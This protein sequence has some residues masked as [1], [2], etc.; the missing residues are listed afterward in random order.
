[1]SYGF[2]SNTDNGY[3]QIDGENLQLK[4]LA[5]G[6]VVPGVIGSSSSDKD[7][8]GNSYYP[9]TGRGSNWNPNKAAVSIAIPSGYGTEDVFLFAKPSNTSQS[10]K[11]IG[12]LFYTSAG[13]GYFKITCPEWVSW[14]SNTV[15]YKLCVINND[16]DDNA[17]YGLRVFS[18]S[19]GL[20]FSSNRANFKGEQFAYGTPS[21]NITS[22]SSSDYGS[23]VIGPMYFDK[24][25]EKLDYYCFLNGCAA[26]SGWQIVTGGSTQ[27]SY[28]FNAGTRGMYWYQPY[29]QFSY[30]SNPSVKMFSDYSQSIAYGSY[31]GNQVDLASTRGIVIGL[32]V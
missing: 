11:M 4:V 8:A 16:E 31:F 32:F 12:C 18:P 9:A 23:T 17:G 29:V 26:Y 10:T 1:M 2:L 24:P 19:G 7:S 22:T 27:Q 14:G 5:S 30:S 13:T 3:A 25:S 21:R 28:T 20:G 6:S 15:D